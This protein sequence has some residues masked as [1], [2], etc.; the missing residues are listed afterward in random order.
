MVREGHAQRF[1]SSE[2]EALRRV[3]RQESAPINS[4]GSEAS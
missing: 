1:A 3:A 4:D 2:G